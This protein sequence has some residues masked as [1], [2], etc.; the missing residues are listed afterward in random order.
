MRI[1]FYKIIN[2]SIVFLFNRITPLYAFVVIFVATLYPYMGSGPDWSFVQRVSQGTRQNFWTYMFYINNQRGMEKFMN[3]NPLNGLSEVWHLACDMQMF[4]I[5]PLFIYPLWRWKRAG[6]AWAIFALF[7]FL[8]A[9]IV[10][11]TLK[12][13][14]PNFML[15]RR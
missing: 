10:I 13:L 8:G 14:P 15:T 6:L 3:N 7:G 4:W 11:F 2:Q 5:S 1:V 9:S 12:D